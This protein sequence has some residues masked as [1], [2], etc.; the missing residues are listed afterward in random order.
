MVVVNNEDVAAASF[1]TLY[2]NNI[3]DY[4]KHDIFTN[5]GFEAIVPSIKNYFFH[6]HVIDF[7]NKLEL[8]DQKYHTNGSIM[9]ENY[10]RKFL[11]P[12]NEFVS[13][14]TDCQSMY[15]MSTRFLK[16]KI[17]GLRVPQFQL[18]NI[19]YTT[20]PS[21]KIFIKFCREVNSVW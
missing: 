13:F 21:H 1:L 19:F 10:N 18:A 7:V 16:N 8:S 12:T 3:E 2:G 14:R 11:F 9:D 4:V 15:F 6:Q 17:N 20:N 5:M